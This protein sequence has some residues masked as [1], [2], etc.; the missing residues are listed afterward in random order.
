MGQLAAVKGCP[1]GFIVMY[2]QV[3]HCRELIG[4]HVRRSLRYA[5]KRR[6][7]EG[8]NLKRHVRS[9]IVRWKQAPGTVV[10]SLNLPRPLNGSSF[11]MQAAVLW[12]RSVS[13]HILGGQR[14]RNRISRNRGPLWQRTQSPL[15]RKSFSPL[16]SFS[17]NIF[18]ANN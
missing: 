6:R 16:R 10:T 14:L 7:V 1:G 13:R 9:Q 18:V 5:T 17:V 8:A 4:M 15:S 12:P 2:Q 3:T 11:T